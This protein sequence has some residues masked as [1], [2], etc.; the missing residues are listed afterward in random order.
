VKEMLLQLLEEIRDNCD[1]N[2]FYSQSKFR[3]V[4]LDLSTDRSESRRAYNLM[5]I[6]IFSI[7]GYSRLRK[8]DGKDKFLA[9][10][11]IQELS[12]DYLIEGESAR[13]AIEA[14]DEF[15][16]QQKTKDKFIV[17]KP[18]IEYVETMQPLEMVQRKK[19]NNVNIQK[20]TAI[21]QNAV[22]QKVASPIPIPTAT[23]SRQSQQSSKPT[24]SSSTALTS[25]QNSREKW[26]AYVEN[27]TM[28]FESL[29]MEFKECVNK[30]FDGWLENMASTMGESYFDRSH[31][32]TA[33][34]RMKAYRVGMEDDIQYEGDIVNEYPHGVGVI[35]WKMDKVY[36][37]EFEK[38]IIHGRGRFIGASGI[39]YDG[40][41]MYNEICGKGCIVSTD[42]TV[43]YGFWIRG[44]LAKILTKREWDRLTTMRG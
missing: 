12:D 17:N 32:S 19:Q 7:K 21:P 42:N 16:K 6:A 38:G 35:K 28:L 1:E 4:I 18:V 36:V 10:Q 11:L 34:K 13:I 22:P 31:W 26:I 33:P 39:Y 14:I 40:E 23:I 37:G 30:A 5:S 29:K 24:L 2:V 41:F 27:G 15:L 44:K 9:S 3:S 20:P 43:T 25:S 8:A